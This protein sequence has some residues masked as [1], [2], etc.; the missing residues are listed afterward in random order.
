M[1]P[2]RPCR[3]TSRDCDASWSSAT[4]TRAAQPRAGLRA[5][6]PGAPRRR[7]T[8]R[9][10]AR[11]GSG[12]ARHR[13]LRRRST[14]SSPP[15]AEWRGPAFAEFA[16]AEWIRPEAIRLDELHVVAIEAR[17]EAE[18]RIGRHEEVVGELEAL[19]VDH[20]LRERFGGQLM[21]ALYRSGRQ[22]EALRAAHELR[23]PPARRVRPRTLGGDPRSRDRD[24][25]R[26]AS[27]DVGRPGRRPA[28]RCGA[29]ARARAHGARYRRRARRSSDASATSSSRRAS[30]SRAASSR[31]S[32][33]A[34]SARPAWRTGSR[35]R[36]APGFADGVRLVELAP[37]RDEAAVRA[38][39]GDALD[40]QQRPNRSLPDSIVELLARAGPAARARQ[41]RARARHDERAGRAHPAL[42]PERARARDEPRAARDPRRGRVVGPAAA[43]A[44]AA[45]TSPSTRWP[46][47]PAVQLFVERAR[48]A[49]HDFELDAD[50]RRRR[51][52]DLHPPRRRAARA[53]ARR[54]AD[55]VD[56]PGAARRTAPRAVPRPGRIAARDRSAPPHAAR[57]R[58]MVVRA[59]HRRRSNACSS[60]CSTF[61]GSFDLE[62]AELVCA[63]H[64]IDA[65]D[66]SGLL[67]RAR[68]QVDGRRGAV[69]SADALPAA[70][71]AARVRSRATRGPAGG[72]RRT[73]RARPRAR[74]PRRAGRQPASAGPTKRAGRA[75]WTRRSTTCGRRTPPRSPTATSTARSG[76]SSRCASTRGAGS[77]TSCS[78]GPTPPWRCRA[79]TDHPLYPVA[80]GVI[81]YGRFVHGELDAA[82][83]AGERGRRRRGTARHRHHRAG[84]TRDRQ[85]PLLPRPRGR[86]ASRGW[87]AWST[88]RPSSSS[89]PGGARQLH[90]LGRRD[91]RREQ[92]R[93]CRVRRAR[94]PRRPT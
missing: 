92:R 82:V 17:I 5:R 45:A 46:T 8:F 85:R 32:G 80:L 84:R 7:R 64:G 36:S 63:G 39:V 50:D 3:A 27:L 65:L 57:P 10:P 18:L 35:P 4:S 93:R 55:A 86:G 73:R 47:I 19:L 60:D 24:P 44:G 33:R 48:A 59:A 22:A 37:V 53:R 2:A 25:R 87:I 9:T 23:P 62:R 6:G 66:V 11:R 70:R 78:P 43:R 77:A 12:A 13:P 14:R 41:L 28:P 26:G 42:V 54:G 58:A 15:S 88:P 75:S 76:S 49:R 74:R 61:A 81:A 67:D 30:S 40:V 71:D 72:A 34:A 68:R 91:V 31:C 1:P 89:L 38:A 56:E 29:R 16:D 90:A 94:R 20:P 69:G 83:E 52:G 21:L 79:S 51:R